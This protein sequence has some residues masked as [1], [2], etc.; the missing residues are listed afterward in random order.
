M[1]VI[2]ALDRSEGTY[3]LT[4]ASAVGRTPPSPSPARNRSVPNAH[5]AG[6]AA[7]RAVNTENQTTLSSMVRRR[8]TR[9][10]TVPMQRAPIITPTRPQ[11]EMTPTSPGVR[12][13]AS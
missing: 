6:A 1:K 10:V 13:Q 5:G 11:E 12:P 9:S 7:S 4:R 8:P 2:E 3:S